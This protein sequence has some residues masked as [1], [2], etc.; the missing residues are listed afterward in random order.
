MRPTILTLI[1]GA[2]LALSACSSG[3]PTQ[4]PTLA[5]AA[6][7]DAGDGG[8]GSATEPPA[9]TTGTGGGGSGGG[10][11]T[12]SGTVHLEVSGPVSGDHL[13]FVHEAVQLGHGIGL[14]PSFLAGRAPALVPVLPTLAANGGLH[15][16]VHPSRHMPQ[17]VRA[18][19]EFLSEKLAVACTAGGACA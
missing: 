3:T 17:R 15:S 2:A 13:S 5:P 12:G 8:G 16:L 1:A 10:G 19:R 18:V 7:A 4:A 9:A 11:T 14:L 6:T